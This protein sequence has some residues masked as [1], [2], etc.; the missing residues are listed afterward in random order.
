MAK[1]DALQG[2]LELLILKI[3]A[4]R[5]PLHGYAIMSAIEQVSQEVLRVE[6]GSLY[7][8]LHRMEE[9]GWIKAAWGTTEAGRKAR[10]YSLT[11]AGSKQLAA[12]ESRW[13][14]ITG[15]VSRVLRMA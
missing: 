13:H 7:P 10:V 3:L 5:A 12:Q 14:T 11:P 2:S 4:R 9:S 8:A 6:E 1:S 15:A